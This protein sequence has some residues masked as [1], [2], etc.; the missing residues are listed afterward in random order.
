MLLYYVTLKSQQYSFDNYDIS[1]GLLNNEVHTICQDSNGIMYFGTA[2]GLSVYDGEEFTNYDFSKGFRQEMVSHIR[3]LPGNEILFFSNTETWYQVIKHRLSNFSAPAGIA[4]RNIYPAGN[5]KWYACTDKGLFSFS[6]GEIARLPLYPSDS[7]PLVN[8]VIQYNDSLLL[9][10][11]N[12]RTVDLFNT[13]NWQRIASSAEK[14]FIRDFFRDAAGNIWASCIDRGVLLLKHHA[15]TGSRIDFE[16][17]TENFAGYA[18]TEFRSVITDRSGIIWM[19]SIGKGIV[20][21]NPVTRSFLRLTTDNGLTSNTIFSLYCDKEDN[22]WIAGN[23]GIQK[24]VQKNAYSYSS[25]NG[26]PADIVYD[27]L[28]LPDHHLLTCGIAGLAYIGMPGQK[29]VDW[30]PPPIDEFLFQFVKLSGEYYGMSD[31]QLFRLGFAAGSPYAKK[32]YPLPGHF[33]AMAVYD[34]DKL[35]FGGD[36]SIAVFEKGRIIPLTKEHVHHIT[37]ICI[38]RNGILW[39]GNRYHEINGYRLQNENGRVAATHLYHYK[40][41]AMGVTDIVNCIT[42]SNTNKVLYGTY[43]G[44]IQVLALNGSV[45]SPVTVINRG[46]GL[47]DN[48]V[49]SFLWEN[50]SSLLAGTGNGMDK[51]SFSKD[52]KGVAIYNINTFY[53]FYG[54]V[55]R[56]R[57]DSGGAMLAGCETG[58]Y[59]IPSTDMVHWAGNN[60]PVLISSIRLLDFPDASIDASGVVEL[61]HSSNAIAINFASP[62]YANGITKKYTYLL[63]GSNQRNWSVPSS[64]HQV[65]FS[66]LSPGHYHF[67]V[68]TVNIYGEVSTNEASCEIVIHPAFWQT[69]WFL[70]LATMMTVAIVYF[71][72]RKRVQNIRQEALFK[73]KIAEAEMIALRAQMNPHFIFNCMNIIDGLITDDRKE[74]AKEFLQKFSRLTR[75][76]LEN[77]QQPLVPLGSD[78]K[79]LRLYIELEAIRYNHRFSYNFDIAPELLNEGYKI[80][81][82]LLQPYVENA[83]VHGLRHK[84][85]GRGILTVT[86]KEEAGQVFVTIEDNGVGRKKS[87]I[88]NK[89]NARP[90]QQMGMS[91]TGKRIALMKLLNPGKIALTVMDINADNETGTKICLVLPL[92]FNIQ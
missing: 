18:H 33:R 30:R 8:C 54:S 4:I 19:G 55:Y 69:N 79:A 58:L 15:V 82:L 50:D 47:S 21:Y 57:A 39:T 5:G 61:E 51:I 45:I 80:P 27:V 34:N 38:D 16:A 29:I 36:T 46:N 20:R 32:V 22:V 12:F 88:I 17:I 90:H 42:A 31:K 23:K 24:L 37:C 77:S 14:I 6:N 89:E 40:G 1:N 87:A 48:N 70:V 72:V 91:V 25:R 73:T 75:L 10:G 13:R 63:R 35:L 3:E 64:E 68:K 44:G 85:V 49:L 76:V 71:I 92:E 7:F 26:L 9:V 53:N 67:E 52:G 81:P 41:R 74:E 2:S 60:M 66:S 59:S 78:L 65:I 28:S 83:I 84:E 56:L 11:R 43:Q 86:M 62:A